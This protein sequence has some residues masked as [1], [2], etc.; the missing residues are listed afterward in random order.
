MMEPILA[1]L[2]KKYGDKLEVEFIDV[3]KVRS[4]VKK[5]KIRVI[6][7]QIF[8]SHEGKEL[9]RHTGFMPEKDILE[10]WKELGYDLKKK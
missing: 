5:Y 1:N 8:F 4:A 10:K 2:K 7:T 6:P 3:R 9:F